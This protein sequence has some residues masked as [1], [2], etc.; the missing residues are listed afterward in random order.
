MRELHIILP[1]DS[2]GRGLAEAEGAER[3]Q[4]YV[5]KRLISETANGLIFVTFPSAL[6]EVRSSVKSFVSSFAWKNFPSFYAL[7]SDHDR[8]RYG[9]LAWHQR[10]NV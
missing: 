9:R 3:G 4:S 5:L 10:I 2:E 7:Q 6:L 8:M 1:P